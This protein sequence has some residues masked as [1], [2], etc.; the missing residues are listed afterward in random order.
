[1][2]LEDNTTSR[3]VV[4]CSPLHYCGVEV[5]DVVGLSV[6]HFE[7]RATD[8]KQRARAACFMLIRDSRSA[9]TLP[10]YCLPYCLFVMNGLI[11]VNI[12]DSDVQETNRVRVPILTIHSFAVYITFEITHNQQ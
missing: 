12:F 9:T 7:R 6:K 1:M 10:C 4:A 3:H 8:G 2:A 5:I 11:N